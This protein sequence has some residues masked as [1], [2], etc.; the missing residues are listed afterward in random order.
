MA[1]APVMYNQAMTS[2]RGHLTSQG[3]QLCLIHG[4]ITRSSVEAI[5][6]AANTQLQH[7]GGVAGAIA[8]VGGPIIQR[9]SDDWVRS[10]GP[11]SHDTPALTSAGDLPC[12]YVIHTV[13]PIWGEGD[14][15]QKLHSAVQSAL[16]LADENGFKSI[17]LPAI[18]TGIYGFPK[19]RGA[20]VI[21]DAII[22]YLDGTPDT[23][24][25]R[26]EITLID[27]PSVEIFAAEFDVRW[28]DS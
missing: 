5:I 22:T 13:G 6:N 12:Q 19:D 3:Q 24:L 21:L 7:G 2:V 28:G 16:R 9:E 26:V 20:R 27:E 23:C 18:S 14:E 4:D 17:A 1:L 25:S 11:L 8:R 15:D 10:H